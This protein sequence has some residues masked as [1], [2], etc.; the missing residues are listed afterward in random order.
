MR[1]PS[2]LS[3]ACA[4]S[5]YASAALSNGDRMVKVTPSDQK[6]LTLCC[7]ALWRRHTQGRH[8]TIT[9]SSGLQR[10]RG[11]TASELLKAR[12]CLGCFDTTEDNL[13]GKTDVT[14]GFNKLTG[15]DRRENNCSGAKP[16]ISCYLFQCN[17]WINYNKSIH[18]I[19]CPRQGAHRLNV[20]FCLSLG[21]LPK[22]KLM[23]AIGLPPPFSGSSERIQLHFH[24]TRRLWSSLPIA[25]IF[26]VKPI[27]WHLPRC[28]G[29]ERHW[30]IIYPQLFVWGF[31][32]GSSQT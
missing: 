13:R 22:R 20:H 10:G 26:G 6:G 9:E 28:K 16:T 24:R 29:V 32:Q 27:M 7:K 8:P 5:S 19:M 25:V 12:S 21:N 31:S 23:T 15:S 1:L 3:H 14:Q 17:Y 2:F 18:T 11:Q 30:R 4:L